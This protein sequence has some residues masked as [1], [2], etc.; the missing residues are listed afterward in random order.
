MG[1]S[2]MPNL[3]SAI[4]AALAAA[5]TI[6]GPQPAAAQLTGVNIS[7]AEVGY[8][9]GRPGRVFFD[10]VYP[11]DWELDYYR[12][13]GA[14]VIRVPVR[15]ERLQGTVGG[16]IDPDELQR[17]RTLIQHAATRGLSVLVD[18]H[19]FGAFHGHMIGSA[20]VPTAAL[21]ELW[22]PLAQLFAANP[23][24]VFGLMNEPAGVS[25][26][27]LRQAIDA[28]LGAIRRAGAENLVLIPGVG[29][30]GAHDFVR[31][32]GGVLDRIDDPANNYAYEVHQYFDFDHS[33]THPDCAAPAAA[34]DLLSGV[35]HWLRERH[36]RGFL[37]EFG[38]GR[39]ENCLASLRA[40]LADLSANRDVWLGWTY[41]AGGPWWGD[42]S[43]T[44]EPKDRR[45][46]PQMSVLSRFFAKTATPGGE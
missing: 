14:N 16:G 34:A 40:V 43:F 21:A 38:T 5:C 31:R 28:A 45:D 37:G 18:I 10:Y 3:L 9:T 30:S 23:R 15:W 22:G 39:S 36:A 11:S 4:V 12:G 42:Y 13:H 17:L 7:G 33:G 1:L 26:P 44:V 29:W 46:R 6:A 32:S 41:W 8:A 20:A 24:V 27:V 19:N 35:T 2:P 25:G